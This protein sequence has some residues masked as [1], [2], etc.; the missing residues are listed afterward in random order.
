[1][2]LVRFENYKLIISEEALFIKSFR[3]LWER[4]RTVDKSK[5]LLEFGF[6]YFQY[7]P[8]SDYMYI[9][10]ELERFEEIKLREGLPSTWKPDKQIIAAIEDYKSLVHTTSS[11]LI[12]DT[13]QAIGKIRKFLRDVDL[14]A[15]DDKGKPKYTIQS[16]TSATAQL[17]KLAKDLAEAQKDID[18]EIAENTRMRGQKVKKV[19]EDGLRRIKQ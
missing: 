9:D 16:I 6:L 7:D 15:E 17:P 12:E 13:R 19:M 10:D 11:L 8:R 2:K 14:A 3:L 1:M 5:V 4:D 18:K